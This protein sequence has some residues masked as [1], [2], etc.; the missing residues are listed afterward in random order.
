MIQKDKISIFLLPAAYKRL[1]K[2]TFLRT[3]N[4][5]KNFLTD[6]AYH[7]KIKK[8]VSNI[9]NCLTVKKICIEKKSS[10]KYCV[11]CPIRTF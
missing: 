11:E 3:W 2:G 5:K 4:L 9:F 7:I 10:G 1:K 8:Y 6:S